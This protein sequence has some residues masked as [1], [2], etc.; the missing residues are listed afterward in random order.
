[1]IYSLEIHFLQRK[2]KILTGKAT[3]NEK[4]DYDFFHLIQSYL[5]CR[6]L[7]QKGLISKK[8]IHRYPLE[9]E[10]S[11]KRYRQDLSLITVTCTSKKQRAKTSLNAAIFAK[12]PRPHLH[13][14]L[15]LPLCFHVHF[16]TA[17][18][19]SDSWEQGPED[20]CMMRHSRLWGCSAQPAPF[21]FLPPLTRHPSI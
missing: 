16:P 8:K 17:N 9:Q 12:E 21:D 5:I 4:S 2:S 19:K 1:M 10:G 18:V 11:L 7:A 15:H 6:N 14:K 20:S 3:Y 13:H